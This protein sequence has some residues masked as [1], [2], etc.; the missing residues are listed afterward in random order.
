MYAVK[1]FNAM[2][3]P[4]NNPAVAHSHIHL[5]WSRLAGTLKDVNPLFQPNHIVP[6]F[7]FNSFPPDLNKDTSYEEG[8]IPNSFDAEQGFNNVKIKF[9]TS[10]VSSSLKQGK[11]CFPKAKSSK[12]LDKANGNEDICSLNVSD[13]RPQTRLLDPSMDTNDIGYFFDKTEYFTENEKYDICRKIWRPVAT[14]AFPQS[15]IYGKKR[16]FSYS[17]LEDYTW[18]QYSKVLD[19][20]FCLPCVVFGRRIGISASKVEKLVTSPLKGWSSAVTRFKMHNKSSIHQTSLLTMQT[21][22]SVKR[23]KIISIE[24]IHD[25]VLNDNIK[26]NRLKLTAIIKT[27]LLC[28]RQNIPLRGHRDDSKYYE[29]VDTGNFQALLNFRIDSGDEIL[30]E[31][32]DKAP[33]NATYRSKS[34][35]NDIISCCAEVVNNNIISEIRSSKHF[36]IIADEVTDCSNKE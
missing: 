3:K 11:I 2:I 35:H 17:W 34:T 29:T 1:L 25:K 21:F 15:I 16:N 24:R 12:P 10:T 26:K 4:R 6:L 8:K 22:L 9:P 28:A 33:K 23:N 19:G 7:F 20:A 5:L 13:Q 14:F 32:F 36:A 31:H 18:L 30:K 27:V